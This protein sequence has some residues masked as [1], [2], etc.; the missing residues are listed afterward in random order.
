[1]VTAII[2]DPDLEFCKE[3][4]WLLGD[5]SKIALYVSTENL[6]E[7]G[8]LIPEKEPAVLIIGPGWD[9]NMATFIRDT[10]KKFPH[11]G[12]LLI[13]N[14]EP[15]A[16]E[17]EVKKTN[18]IEILNF[19]FS[20]HFL[21]SAL[22]EL[23]EISQA[24]LNSTKK[25]PQLREQRDQGSKVITVFGTK[26]GVGKTVIATNLAVFL[27][28][29]TEAKI[30]LVDLDLQFGDVGVLLRLHP[31]HTI[32]DAAHIVTDLSQKTLNQLL[33][34]HTSGLK[35]LPAPLEPELADVITAENIGKILDVLKKSADLV[36]IDT[37]PSFNDVVL[38][39][40]DKSDQ[41][42]LVT[43]MDLPSIK[44][45]KQCLQTFELLKYLPKKSL[46]VI[47]RVDP[48]LGVNQKEVEKMLCKEAKVAIATDRHVPLSVNRGQP[49][50]IDFPKSQASQGLKNLSEI[51]IKSFSLIS[52][53]G[54][55]SSLNERGGKS[56]TP[57]PPQSKTT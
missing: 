14:N 24:F 5:Y 25:P 29:S 51:F 13:L 4:C 38:T 7:S 39:A 15:Q 11:A 2:S 1:M 47:N 22:E 52:S 56:V 34:S 19:P 28:Q 10:K 36:V 46:L 44:S 31:K 48:F 57:R 23:F 45:T 17:A 30:I 55:L 27:A 18:G 3:V 21:V 41:I 20:G 12:I 50:V 53:K 9:K 54:N 37:P 26:G 6:E 40:L 8:F 35:I 43:S 49:I 32:Y 16:L 42:C 33:I